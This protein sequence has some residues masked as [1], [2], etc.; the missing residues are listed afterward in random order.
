MTYVITDGCIDVMDK[1]CVS[2]CP[3][4]CIYEGDR[5]MYIDPVG[6]IECGACV[7]VCPQDAIYYDQDLPEDRSIFTAASEHLFQ[8]V[9]TADGAAAIGR[10]GYDSPLLADRL[11]ATPRSDPG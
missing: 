1:S 11:A 2:V 4:D 3:V 10:L 7:D 9:D 5:L 6:C 8:G